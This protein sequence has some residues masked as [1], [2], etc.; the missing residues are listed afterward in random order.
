[1]MLKKN[2]I[3][4]HIGIRTQINDKLPSMEALNIRLA[5]IGPIPFTARPGRDGQRR[6]MLNSFSAAVGCCVKPTEGRE[7]C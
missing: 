4:P 5:T 1:M 2:T 6:I 7:S 3:P